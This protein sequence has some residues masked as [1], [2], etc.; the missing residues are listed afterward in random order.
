[1][2]V[3]LQAYKAQVTYP[4]TTSSSGL[5]TCFN[6]S[7]DTSPTFPTLTIHLDGVDLALPLANTFVLMEANTM[8]LAVESTSQFLA[9]FG[10]IQQQNYHIV[11]DAQ[12]KQIG[13]A[14]LD[15]KSA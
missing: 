10:N 6:T 7:K 13:F 1:M 3:M 9:I 5:S 12:N 11:Y 4:T 2:D 15:C 8:C 14:P